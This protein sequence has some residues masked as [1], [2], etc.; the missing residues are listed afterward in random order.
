MKHL[1]ISYIH[2]D[3]FTQKQLSGNSLTVF[4]MDKDPKCY[5]DNLLL[6]ITREMRHFESI[7]VHI[8][9]EPMRDSLC[10]SSTAEVLP[11]ILVPARIFACSG[12]LDFAGHPVLG[13]ASSI[14]DKYFSNFSKI[15]V[16]FELT[17]NRLITT[18]VTQCNYGYQAIMSQGTPQFLNTV[19]N[20]AQQQEL[21]TSL[22]LSFKDYDDKYPMEVVST[23]LKYLIVPVKSHD[24]LRKAKIVD[25]SFGQVLAKHNAECVYAVDVKTKTARSWENDGSS[26]DAATG[27]AAGPFAAYLIK[28]G[29]AKANEILEINQGEFIGRPS[30]LT[31]QIINDFEDVLV[32]GGVCVLGNGCIKLCK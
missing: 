6:S 20:T 27:S 13:A 12:E 24:I 7:F 29:I 17:H 8:P 31:V 3:V 19:V 11:N 25:S 28:H 30:K 9:D 26:E 14:H 16:Q 22:N 23:G 10:F 18:N 1:N 15:Q 2:C 21:L 4:F 5:E 32:T